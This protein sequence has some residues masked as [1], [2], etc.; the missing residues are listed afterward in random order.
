MSSRYLTVKSRLAIALALLSFLTLNAQTSL[1]EIRT[2]PTK[3]G[4]VYYAYPGV[5]GVKHTPVPKG[6]HPFYVSH[7]GRHGSR[8]LIS[9]RDYTRVME[10]LAKADSA[11]V[12]TPLGHDIKKR[13]DLVWNEAR[14][15][16][17]E[18]TPLGS[19]QHHDIAQR[20]MRANP[21]I[22]E[23]KP[24]ITAK[25]TTVMR[26][27]HSMFAFIEGLK[28]ID[29]SLT[30]SRE[31]GQRAMDYLNYHDR[32]TGWKSSEKGPWYQDFKKFRAEMTKPDR[33]IKSIFNDSIYI[34]RNID[35]VETMWGLYWIA[36][37]MQNMETP[38]SFVDIFTPQE[39][40]DLWQVFN[41]N[42]F[43]CNSSYL[44]AEGAF[45]DNA[46]NLVSNILETADDYIQNNKNGATLRFG[47]DGNIIPLTA[48]LNIEGCYADVTDPYRLADNYSDFKI[49]PM[50]ANLQIIFY[51]NSRGDIIAKLL[52]N[53][54]EVSIP[55]ETDIAPYYHWTDLRRYLREVID[56]PYAKVQERRIGQSRCKVRHE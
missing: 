37:D 36:V 47:H 48:L 25:S 38:I 49:S 56:T 46:K 12:L 42:F 18:L 2:T 55:V 40:Y 5:D 26:C 13:L 15:R 51:K 52:L 44:P 8:Y 14:G 28:E 4:G 29:P 16:G 6:Y 10:L 24:E 11:D 9:D 41:F 54:R 53:E 1:D 50:A 23:G 39:L 45:V 35:P 30:I 19:R 43:A 31:S 34:R 32:A 17:G 21:T 7:Y 22:F 3:A 20:L 27:A 33:L